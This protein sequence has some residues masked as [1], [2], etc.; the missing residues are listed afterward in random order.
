[1]LTVFDSLQLHPDRDNRRT[2]GHR[3][4]NGEAG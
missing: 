3:T 1:M 2:G 4:T